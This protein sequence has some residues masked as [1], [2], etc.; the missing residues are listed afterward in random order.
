MKVKRR[1]EGKEVTES[2]E[3]VSWRNSGG[4]LVRLK[5]GDVIYRKKKDIVQ[6]ESK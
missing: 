2:V 5:N 4:A 1:V 6:E 3:L